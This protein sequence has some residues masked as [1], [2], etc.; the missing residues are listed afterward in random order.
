MAVTT[1]QHGRG[2]AVKIRVTGGGAFTDISAYV[3]NSTLPF[4]REE[5]ETTTYDPTLTEK[6]FQ[7]GNVDR[8]FSMAGNWS[9]AVGAILEPFVAAASIDIQ[10]G[11]VGSLTGAAYKQVTGFVTKYED[12][13]DAGDIDKW[14]MDIRVSGAVTTGTF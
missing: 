6:T 9:T 5:H 3:A 11:K 10:W 8:T 13:T 12:G 4:N 14:S 7:G 1:Y 2:T